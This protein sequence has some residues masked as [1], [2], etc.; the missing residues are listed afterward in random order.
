MPLLGAFVITAP[1][2]RGSPEPGG[3][4]LGAAPYPAGGTLY[5]KILFFADS[6]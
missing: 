1:Y 2:G 6:G 4:G 5:G 3:S